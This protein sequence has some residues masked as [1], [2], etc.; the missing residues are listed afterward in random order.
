MGQQASSDRPPGDRADIYWRRRVGALAMGLSVAGL[1]AWAV[2]GTL[3]GA[4]A[5]RDAPAATETG[6]AGGNLPGHRAHRHRDA[7]RHGRRGHRT[8]RLVSARRHGVASDAAGHRRARRRPGWQVAAC[9]PGDVVLSLHQSRAAYSGRAWPQFEADVVSTAADPCTFSTGPRFVSVV[10]R[11]GRVPL[12]TSAACARG[13][14][15]VSVL[16]RG[17][18][19]VLRFWWDRAVQAPGCRGKGR[20][21]RPGTFVATAVSGRLISNSL[22]FML[23]APGPAVP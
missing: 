22:V 10:V 16:T 13:G 1:I 5:V 17:V 20:P 14:R 4:P 23:R 2:N 21:V 3:S 8:T 7:G 15:G 6:H 12:W 19:V 9:P 11:A 18:P